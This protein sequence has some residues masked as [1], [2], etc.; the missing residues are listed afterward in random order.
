MNAVSAVRKLYSRAISD[1]VVKQLGDVLCAAADS[2]QGRG[3]V[4][5]LGDGDVP[6]G[7]QRDDAHVYC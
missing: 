5:W 6:L 3:M 7:C 1:K 2:H 4:G